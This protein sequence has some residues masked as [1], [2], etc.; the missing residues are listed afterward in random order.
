MD[1]DTLLERTADN[2]LSVRRLKGSGLAQLGDVWDVSAQVAGQKQQGQFEIVTL[3]APTRCT[4]RGG[5]KIYAITLDVEL[6]AI[7]AEATRLGVKILVNARTLRGRILLKPLS[8]MAPVLQS[9]FAEKVGWVVS[10]LMD[11]S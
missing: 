7:G 8:V 2:R 3:D 9:R 5:N 1:L 11:Q 4:L 10:R 6:S